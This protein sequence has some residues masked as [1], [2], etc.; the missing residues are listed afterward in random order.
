RARGTE[1]RQE[2]VGQRHGDGAGVAERDIER[3]GGKR[4][5]AMIITAIERANKAGLYR[6]WKKANAHDSKSPALDM[7]NH[8]GGHQHRRYLPT[9]RQARA[10]KSQLGPICDIR[11]TIYDLRVGLGRNGAKRLGVAC[12]AG[13]SRSA[14]SLPPQGGTTNKKRSSRLGQVEERDKG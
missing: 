9:P 14:T 5:F 11:Y 13:F 3:V 12:S 2:Q 6:P 1:N 7:P 8:F 4:D 10:V